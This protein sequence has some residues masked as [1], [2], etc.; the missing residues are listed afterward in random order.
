MASI[1]KNL[2]IVLQVSAEV[3]QDKIESAYR[4]MALRYHPDLNQSRDATFLMQEVNEAYAVLRNPARR[5][6]YDRTFTTQHSSHRQNS[7]HVHQPHTAQKNW[8]R[9]TPAPSARP[10]PRKRPVEET[11]PSVQESP[12]EQL[13]IFHLNGQSYAFTI[14]DVA[15]VVLMQ[16]II[17]NPHAPGFVGGIINVRGENTPVIDLRK[18]LGIE[19][20]PTTKDTG[21]ILSRVEHTLVGFVVDSIE[22]YLSVPSGIITSPPSFPGEQ[23]ITF[24]KG[25]ARIGFQLVVLLDLVGLFTKNQKEYLAGFHTYIQNV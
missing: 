2:Y 19:L 20:I 14:Q 7:R 16:D 11:K 24:I 21:I 4:R 3:N 1:S 15:S 8:Q 9:P 18:H 23:N 12:Q 6:E 17:P 5:A 10:V 25:F 22:N 13:V